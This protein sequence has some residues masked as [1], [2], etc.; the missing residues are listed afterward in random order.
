M[1]KIGRKGSG[2]P[3][4]SV[5]VKAELLALQAEN[6]QLREQLVNQE[7]LR[8]GGAAAMIEGPDDILN[9]SHCEVTS[10]GRREPNLGKVWL[11]RVLSDKAPPGVKIPDSVRLDGSKDR[12]GNPFRF[13]RKF[14]TDTEIEL[15]E[16][17]IKLLELPEE[18]EFQVETG[19]VVYESALRGNMGPAEADC[20]TMGFEKVRWRGDALT[21]IAYIRHYTVQKIAERQESLLVPA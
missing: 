21:Y 2:T 9:D 1:S 13:H 14:I 4:S 5:S 15:P 12:S 6:E 8:H 16:D 7:L 10:G 19:S 11:C 18:R 20:A 3:A 17:V